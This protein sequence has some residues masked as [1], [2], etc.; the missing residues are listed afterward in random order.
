[1]GIKTSA[2]AALAAGANASLSMDGSS[3]QEG[4]V[5]L[6]PA[7]PNYA[8]QIPIPAGVDTMQT[9]RF[10]AYMIGSDLSSIVGIN[11]R[12]AL[13]GNGGSLIA[14]AQQEINGRTL[15]IFANFFEYTL[16]SDGLASRTWAWRWTLSPVYPTMFPV[17][18]D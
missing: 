16:E 6:A 10:E 12:V 11:W 5:T 18:E 1:M 3:S 2:V 15:T 9:I 4:R 17:P 8:V 7:D 14:G 13:R